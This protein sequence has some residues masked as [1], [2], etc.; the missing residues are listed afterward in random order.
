MRLIQHSYSGL[1]GLRDSTAY[2]TL[3]VDD[4]SV[5]RAWERVRDQ[6]ERERSVRPVLL[7]AALAGVAAAVALVF[8]WD[9]FADPRPL[10]L[11]AGNEARTAVLADGS[12]IT[13]EAGS[14]VTEVSART[15]VMAYRLERGEADFRVTPDRDR[16]FVVW[17]E[18]VRI[19]VMGT[20]FAVSIAE[21]EQG[22]HSVGVNV[23]EGRVAVTSSQGVDLLSAGDELK[24]DLL[25]SS[26]LEQDDVLAPSPRTRSRASERRDT[27]PRGPSTSA[28]FAA[29]REAQ[30]AGRLGEAIRRYEE[31][32]A[33]RPRD[34][35]ASLAAFELGRIRMDRLGQPRRAARDFRR[36]RSLAP[37]SP[38]SDDATARLVQIY[39]QSGQRGLCRRYRRI[40]RR[41]FPDGRHRLEVDAFCS[42]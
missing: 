3:D 6:V 30:Q 32:L 26:E 9:G 14:R 13:A 10:A 18:G 5:D 19:E 27:P 38:L 34:I 37:T 11:A 22:P 1:D 8:F 23:R 21:D 20:Q 12:E 39:D 36:A 33:R 25:A 28:L 2:V 4:S 15:G 16:T 42:F 7:A 17:A 29:A 40:Y 31:L 35:R 41:S 24:V